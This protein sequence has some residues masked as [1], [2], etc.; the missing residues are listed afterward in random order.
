MFHDK[1]IAANLGNFIRS[2]HMS[3][4][5]V[6]QLFPIALCS[7]QVPIKLSYYLGLFISFLIYISKQVVAKGFETAV[8]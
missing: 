2:T 7:E 8:T 1:Q 4:K 6:I 3:P 5:N